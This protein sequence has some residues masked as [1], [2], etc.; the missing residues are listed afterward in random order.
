[1]ISSQNSSVCWCFK[2]FGPRDWVTLVRVTE[3]LAHSFG[4]KGRPPSFIDVA[5]FPFSFPPLPF[6]S[7]LF[8][9]PPLTL[10]KDSKFQKLRDDISTG[11]QV[12]GSS[13]LLTGAQVN[14]VNFSVFAYAM[15]F[16]QN[17][18]KETRNLYFFQHCLGEAVSSVTT[19]VLHSTLTDVSAPISSTAV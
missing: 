15:S 13:V 2:C 14:C 3:M 9:I 17:G 5:C 4:K 11:A 7:L 19:G 8:F 10:H 18:Q 1:M 12:C 6:P 16:L